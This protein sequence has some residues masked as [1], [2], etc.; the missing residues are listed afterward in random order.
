MLS[1]D[2][3]FVLFDDARQFGAANGRY[4]HNLHGQL[5]LH[6]AHDVHAMLDILRAALAE[7]LHVAGYLSYEAGLILEGKTAHLFNGENF[8][9]GALLGWFGFFLGYNEISQMDP[10]LSVSDDFNLGAL[11]PEIGRDEYQSMFD[12]IQDYIL[13]GDIYQANLTFRCSAEFSGNPLSLYAALRGHASAG[14][15]GILNGGNFHILSFSPELFFTLKNGQITA[16]PMKGTATVLHNAVDDAAAIDALRN[17]PKQRAENLMI[18]DLLR[19]DL[20]KICK[21]FSV[22]VPKLFHVETYP[23]VHQMTSTV[24]GILYDDHDAVDILAQIFPC[25]SITGAPKI[26]SMEIIDQCEKS[27]RGPYCGSMGW[28]DPNGDAAFNVAIRSL[29]MQHGDDRFLMGLGSGIVADSN[30]SDEWAECLAKG[31]FIAR[32]T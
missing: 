5:L 11:I 16:R 20:S 8:N 25:G 27:P 17:D 26:R 31:A 32:K 6:T 18:V 22:K 21:P 7:G 19:N 14:Y 28:I 24:T 1:L 13:S 23:T 30:A 2:R 10:L 4:Y 9:D 12:A 3:P 29:S 15:G